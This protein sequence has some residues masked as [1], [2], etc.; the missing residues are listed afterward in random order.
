M[1][2]NFTKISILFFFLTFNFLFTSIGSVFGQTATVVTP[3]GGTALG[4]TNGTGA[5]PVCRYYNSLRYQVHYTAAELSAAGIPANS[6]ITRI[7]WNVTEASGTLANCTVRMANTTQANGSAHNAVATTLVKNPF[8]YATALGYNDIILDVPFIWNGT[9]N[10]LVEICTGTTNPF[11]SPYGGV[12][13]RTGYLTTAAG[14]RSY[15]VD[16]ASACAT[17]TN[18]ALTNKPVIR[19]TWTGSTACAG[20]PNAGTAAISATSGC[21]GASVSLAGSG[22]STG[23]GIGYQWQSSADNVTWTNIAG[24]TAANYTAT[25]GSTTYYRLRTTCSNSGITSTS[26]VVQYSTVTCCNYTFNM[27]DSYGDGWNGATMQIRQGTTVI[28]TIGSTFTT[29]TSASVTVPIATGVAYNL[30]Y[31]A[32]G[33]YPTEVGINVLN[34][35]GANIYS[36]G[37]GLGTVGA[38]LCGTSTVTCT[39]CPGVPAGCT[40]LT[41]YG[42]ATAGTNNT[43]VTISTCNYQSEYSTVSGIVS[44]NAYQFTYSLGGYITIRSGAYNGAI[45]AQGNAPLNWTANLSGTV[46]V[47][48]NTN[49][50]CGTASLC[51]TSGV[52]CTSCPPPPVTI[53]N[54]LVCSATA[55]ACGQTV[56]GTTV[57][58]NNAGTGENGTCTVTQ[59]MPG[60]WYV[61]PG[62]GQIMTASLCGTAWDSK[63]S[64]FSGTSCSAL[65]CVGGNDDGGPACAGTS[66]SYTWTSVVGLNYYILVHGYGSN[67][68]FSIALTCVAPPPANPSS[69]TASTSAV[70]AGAGTS[71]TLTANGAVGTVYWFSGSCGTTG[72]ISTGNSLVVSPSATTT[73]FARNFNGGQWSAGCAS[74]T[75]VVNVLPIVNAGADKTVCDG[76]GTTLNGSAT[77]NTS[78]PVSLTVNTTGGNGCTGGAMFDIVTGATAVTV[79]S[80]DISPYATAVQTVNVYYRVGTYAGNETNSAAWTL[81]GAY[82]VN[83]TA[84]VLANMPVAN[85]A[86]PANS[87]YGIYINYNATYTTLATSVSNGTITVNTG[88]GLCSAFGGV[89]AGRT[90]NGAVNYS[91]GTNTT[92]SYS[93]SPATALS[94]S[95]IATPTASPSSNIT[96][97]LT[98]TAN[99]CSASDQVVVNVNSNSTAPT[100]NTIAGVIC[101]NTNVNMVAS[102]GTAGTGAQVAWYT[103][104]NGTGTFLGYGNSFTWA[105]A[106]TQTIYARREGTC[107]TTTDAQSTVSVRSYVY[108]ANAT[109]SST[110]CTDNNGWKHFY[111][112]NDLIFSAEGDFSN[113]PSGYPVVTISNNNSFYQQNAGPF[114][115]TACANGLTPGEQRFEMSR[116]WN[117][118][119][120]GG[121]P[122][123]SYNVRFYYQASEKQAIETA[124]ANWI[125][126]YPACNY[127]PKYATANGFYWFKN[128]GSAYVAPQYDGTQYTGPSGSTSNGVNYAQ[129]NG[130]TSFSGGTG[131]IILVPDQT[132]PIDWQSFTGTTDNKFNYL[133]WVTAS[134]QNTQSFE[135][136]RS[137]D[138]VS[139]ERI[140]TVTAAGTSNTSK[141]YNF[142]DRTPLVGQNYYRIR[143]I[144]N[145]GNDAYSNVVVLEVSGQPSGYTVYPNPTADQITLELEA[146]KTE[147]VEVQ[148]MDVL[149][150]VVVEKSF[151]VVNGKN[152]LQLDLK[153]LV[154]G[155]YSLK[156]SYKNTGRV[157]TEKIVKK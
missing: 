130:V 140:G 73:Y 126:T 71:V 31:S 125:A 4:N 36:L 62:N 10:L 72:Q 109:S 77:A 70:C 117:L 113:C 139:F 49:S 34:A 80:F 138:G 106:S 5:D 90:F 68:A 141:S 111:A 97:T 53:A 142:T 1:K 47:H 54:D 56:S 59:T 37:A 99:G 134:E 76:L 151:S 155:N 121:A 27:T 50:S 143:M 122:I 135:V 21:A 108:A 144:E 13:A 87:T 91:A 46:Y 40:N 38:S 153:K 33:S 127:Q 104:P 157:I 41:A 52:V 44:G 85:L 66:A 8:A 123:G 148:I 124:A 11:A 14:A 19:I 94:N 26:N 82:S 48:Y 154:A 133:N 22:L 67:S 2:Y 79:T 132:L 32:G 120:G 83:G 149:G 101:P 103:G 35:S 20:T 96:Y 7:A 23:G 88:A 6:T 29:G 86:I 78:T 112:G 58:A 116:S 110:Y 69:I 30:F 24:A 100:L 12:Q 84:N 60:V 156:A 17:A 16:G 137:K 28:A 15:R 152:Q 3:T 74:T 98:A 63:I 131:A 81:L 18:S 147:L 119:M 51:G 42:S 105:P 39:S 136:Q 45:V 118:D 75:I 95:S 89:N 61:V 43:A 65:T 102:G 55:L 107:N 146:D 115:A 114:Q 145:T 150:R 9:S 129:L 128:T 93:W 92:P 64:I 57:G 25:P